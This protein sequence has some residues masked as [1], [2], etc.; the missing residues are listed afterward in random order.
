[1]YTTSQCYIFS[2]C[3]N[4]LS[5]II[6]RQSTTELGPSLYVW[7]FSFSASRRYNKFNILLSS[8]RNVF[9]IFLST[10]TKT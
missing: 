5:H 7:S 9:T 1:V 6:H 4:K 10:V 2:A 3:S 8:D